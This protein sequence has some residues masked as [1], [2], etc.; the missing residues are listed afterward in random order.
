MRALDVAIRK[1]ESGMFQ[2]DLNGTI[3]KLMAGN[4]RGYDPIAP[5]R[6]ECRLKNGYLGLPMWLAGKQF[7][8]LAHRVVWTVQMGEIPAG[9]DINHLDGNKT[10]N[11]PKNLEVATRSQNHRHAY[12]TG[13]RSRPKS[14]PAP[15][16]DEIR[17]QAQELRVAGLTYLQIANQLQVSQ[18]TAFRA[19]NT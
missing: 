5:K 19:V 14:I 10:N 18:T 8:A 12:L 4:G 3:W 11:N 2:V 13:L 17:N 9:M 6:A 7:L 1:I 16:L 15:I